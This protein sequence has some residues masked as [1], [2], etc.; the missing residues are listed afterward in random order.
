MPYPVVR[1]TLSLV[2]MESMLLSVG[3]VHAAGPS[4]ISSCKKMLPPLSFREQQL[5]RHRNW[6]AANKTHEALRSQGTIAHGGIQ[7]WQAAH[8][9][10]H[11]QMHA[12]RSTYHQEY[13][14]LCG[15]KKKQE[16]WYHSF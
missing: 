16:Q 11:T 5:R 4:T 14:A 1:V 8:R 15:R 12:L 13:I 9:I 2:L 3:G 6:H 7:T 10:H